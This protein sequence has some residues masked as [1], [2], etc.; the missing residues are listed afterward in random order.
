MPEPEIEEAMLRRAVPLELYR[1]LGDNAPN[2]RATVSCMRL[3]PIKRAD[4]QLGH[5]TELFTP[6]AQRAP[7]DQRT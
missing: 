7:D 1:V 3:T 4:A 6:E 5:D 2:T